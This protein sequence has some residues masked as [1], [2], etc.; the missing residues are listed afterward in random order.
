MSS[1]TVLYIS[2]IGYAVVAVVAILV[3]DASHRH[4]YEEQRIHYHALLT[5][6]SIYADS[7]KSS[8]TTL[9][10]R[11]EQLQDELTGLLASNFELQKDVEQ[12][13][14]EMYSEAELKAMFGE[15]N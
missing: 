7:L 15:P 11:Q 1:D 10:A 14:R 13:H 3:N 9:L 6:L 2:I 12:L 8:N 5:N 4:A